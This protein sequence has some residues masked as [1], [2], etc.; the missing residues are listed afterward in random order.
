MP[1]MT[2]DD[3]DKKFIAKPLMRFLRKCCRQTVS[4]KDERN[5]KLL[6]KRAAAL[7]IWESEA[8]AWIAHGTRIERFWPEEGEEETE[9]EEQMEDADGGSEDEYNR[10]DGGELIEDFVRN[11]DTGAGNEV[12]QP[13]GDTIDTSKDEANQDEIMDEGAEQMLMQAEQDVDMDLDHDFGDPAVVAQGDSAAHA[14][15]RAESVLLESMAGGTPDD[16]GEGTASASRSRRT[17]QHLD[18]TPAP[19]TGEGS[20]SH[21]RI[22]LED[23]FDRRQ[24]MSLDPSS[25]NGYREGLEATGQ[26]GR[27]RQQQTGTH[28]YNLSV[29]TMAEMMWAERE[30]CAQAQDEEEPEP[31]G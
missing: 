16:I 23:F 6:C 10:D 17:E 15:T 19:G 22:T 4:Q 30:G 11:H 20:S 8:N 21:E 29:R 27:D 9:E 28:R 3:F 12:T 2:E 24:A 26:R 7:N 18:N 31:K 1:P 14:R 25:S 13:I 5:K